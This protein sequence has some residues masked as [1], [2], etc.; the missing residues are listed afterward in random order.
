MKNLLPSMLIVSLSLVACGTVNESTV[1]PTVAL[2]SEQNS[3][4]QQVSSGPVSEGQVP[5]GYRSAMPSSRLMGLTS[6]NLSAQ[7]GMPMS[8]AIMTAQALESSGG[9]VWTENGQS[10][11]YAVEG[12][13]LPLGD[14]VLKRTYGAGWVITLINGQYTIDNP[15]IASLD[16][17]DFSFAFPFIFFSTTWSGQTTY[18]TA[19]RE[20][21]TTARFTP[22]GGTSTSQINV[23]VQTSMS[24][25]QPSWEIGVLQKT[26][27]ARAVGRYCGST[28]YPPAPAVTWNNTLASVARAHSIDISYKPLGNDLHQGRDGSRVGTRVSRSGYSWTQLGENIAAGIGGG[29]AAAVQAWLNSPSHCATLM[30]P[31]LKDLGVGYYFRQGSAYGVYWTQVYGTH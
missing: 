31:A 26:N 24:P 3:R 19:R 4:E 2:S 6:S 23:I 8:Q 30:D 16:T 15:T 11:F 20:G 14:N 28:Y 18:A 1:T 12:E 13:R 9:Y 22:N 10:Y 27:E 17:V 29:P 5:A 21:Y 25:V 7:S